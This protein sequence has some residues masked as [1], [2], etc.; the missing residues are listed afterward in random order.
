MFIV[1]QVKHLGPATGQQPWIWP[2]LPEQRNH[3]QQEGTLTTHSELTAPTSTTVFML[4]SQSSSPCAVF[5]MISLCSHIFLCYYLVQVKTDRNVTLTSLGYIRGIGKANAYD[6]LL[7]ILR[8]PFF[9]SNWS[10][11][12]RKENP[13]FFRLINSSLSSDIST[14]CLCTQN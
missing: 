8:C 6:I 2:S 4:K 11:T 5:P 1:S 14:N 9:S 10:P 12:P 3:R 7:S 13:W